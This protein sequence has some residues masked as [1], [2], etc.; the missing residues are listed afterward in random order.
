MIFSDIDF[1]YYEC[2]LPN[3]L[4]I[5]FIILNSIFKQKIPYN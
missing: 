2:L 3:Y 4:N 1:N 5:L